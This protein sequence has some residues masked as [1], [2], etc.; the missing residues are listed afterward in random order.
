MPKIS[1]TSLGERPIE[2]SSRSISVGCPTSAPPMLSKAWK[3]RVDTLDRR[4]QICRGGAPREAS[5]AKVLVHREVQKAAAPLEHLHQTFAHQ[6]H[7]IAGTQRLPTEGDR[8]R[9]QFAALRQKQARGRLHG[10]GLPG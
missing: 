4:R 2:G 5:R 9:A 10:G 6:A 7:R 8:A 3:A 1:S